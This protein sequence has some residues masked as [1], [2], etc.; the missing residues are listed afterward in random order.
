MSSKVGE[1]RPE[2]IQKVFLEKVTSDMGLKGKAE[3]VVSLYLLF[4]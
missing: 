1:V 2:Q 3:V 4:P